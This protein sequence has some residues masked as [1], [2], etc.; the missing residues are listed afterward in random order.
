MLL[1]G[2]RDSA[3]SLST[4]LDQCSL[5]SNCS[6]DDEEEEA[7]VE[8]ALEHVELACTQLA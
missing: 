7:I 6:K 5:H 8:E 1:E 4:E 3:H 2:E